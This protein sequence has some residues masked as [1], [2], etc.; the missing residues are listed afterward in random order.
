M[1]EKDLEQI[2][3]SKEAGTVHLEWITKCTEDRRQYLKS[4]LEEAREI[5]NGYQG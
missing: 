1:P 5:I 2:E 4:L 3:Q